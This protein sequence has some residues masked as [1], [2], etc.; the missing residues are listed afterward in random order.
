[1][2]GIMLQDG[3][4]RSYIEGYYTADDDHIRA[5]FGAYIIG[6]LEACFELGEWVE[7]H[8]KKNETD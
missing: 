7:E 1:M 5:E 3:S 8:L 6:Y 4:I 2:K